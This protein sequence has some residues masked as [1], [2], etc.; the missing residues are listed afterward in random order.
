MQACTQKSDFYESSSQG[1]VTPVPSV[2]ISAT[3][4]KLSQ[5]RKWPLTFDFH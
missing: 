2:L 3:A 5:D 4:V 1:G